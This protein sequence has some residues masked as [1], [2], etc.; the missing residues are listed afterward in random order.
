[1]TEPT[2]YQAWQFWFAVLQSFGLAAL[3]IYTWWSNRAK[4]TAARFLELER[5]FAKCM[6]TQDHQAAEDARTAD[7]RAHQLR[8]GELELSLSRVGGEIRNMPNRQE[9]AVLSHD[10]NGLTRKLGTVEGRLDGL[11]HTLALI[12]EFLINEGGRA[13]K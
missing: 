7:C 3:G 8:T 1:M 10:I 11:N 2:N 13:K 12:N 9:M 6:P 4:V 5:Q